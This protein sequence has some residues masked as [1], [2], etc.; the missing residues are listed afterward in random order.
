MQ[1]KGSGD[2]CNVVRSAGIMLVSDCSQDFPQT[3]GLVYME[4]AF[5]PISPSL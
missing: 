5:K 1:S 2:T 4:H 3:S